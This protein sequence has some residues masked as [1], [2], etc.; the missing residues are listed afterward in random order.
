MC[1]GL[2]VSRFR[3]RCNSR[4]KLKFH[5]PNQTPPSRVRAAHL[6]QRAGADDSTSNNLGELCLG[7]RRYVRKAIAGTPAYT[8]SRVMLK[9]KLTEAEKALMRYALAVVALLAVVATM[10][11]KYW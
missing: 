5:K 2:H 10:A 4:P 9:V 3:L 7:V 8:G 11:V 6:V 1:W